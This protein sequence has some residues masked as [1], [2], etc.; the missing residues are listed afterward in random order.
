MT[1]KNK[2][3][4]F[5]ESQIGVNKAFDSLLYIEL[6]LKHGRFKMHFDYEI[7]TDLPQTS[8]MYN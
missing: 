2:R 6:A 5:T 4:S 3:V 8:P 7:V 1:G